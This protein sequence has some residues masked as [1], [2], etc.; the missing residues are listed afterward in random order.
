MKIEIATDAYNHRRYSRPYIAT[1]DFTDLKGTPAWGTFIGTHGEAGFCL[2]E[3]NPWD[4][5][6]QGQRD[7]RGNKGGADYYQVGSDGELASLASKAEAY[8]AWKEYRESQAA[9]HAGVESPKNA[10]QPGTMNAEAI[11]SEYGIKL[12]SEVL[13]DE[14]A[15]YSV[16]IGGAEI[17]CVDEKHALELAF[18]FAVAIKN[19]TNL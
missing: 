9:T 18:A 5:I 13:S 16:S 14:S 19:A 1:L 8:K 3:A 10:R 4:I 6:M 11:K 2:I 17:S 7:G 15:V 12:H